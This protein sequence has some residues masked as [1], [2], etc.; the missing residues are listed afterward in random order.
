MLVSGGGNFMLIDLGSFK[1]QPDRSH[2]GLLH[3]PPHPTDLEA[4]SSSMYGEM[5]L[6]QGFLPA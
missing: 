3:P 6:G 1:L 4:R 5:A 2:L